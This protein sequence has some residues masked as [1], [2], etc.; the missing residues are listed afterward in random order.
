MAGMAQRITDIEDEVHN[1][2]Q[3]ILSINKIA[4]VHS[5]YRECGIRAVSKPKRKPHRPSKNCKNKIESN[6]SN[7]AVDIICHDESNDTQLVVD[8]WRLQEYY[9]EPEV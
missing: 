1:M 9:D 2:F 3:V 4:G 5:A 7:K 8:P 6:S